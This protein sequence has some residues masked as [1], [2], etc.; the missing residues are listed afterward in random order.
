MLHHQNDSVK[1][2][3]SFVVLVVAVEGEVVVVVDG[4]VEHWFHFLR[5]FSHWMQLSQKLLKN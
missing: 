5:F 4:A 2:Y 3:P 1:C